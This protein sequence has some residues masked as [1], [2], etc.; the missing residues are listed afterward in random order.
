MELESK[1]EVLRNISENLE[2]SVSS[3]E[4]SS[5]KFS[6]PWYSCCRPRSF[7]SFDLRSKNEQ[8]FVVD[9][10]ILEGSLHAS[11][12]EVFRCKNCS[13]VIE[14]ERSGYDARLLFPGIN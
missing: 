4:E 2:D 12:S 9:V 13:E 6:P 3:S 10:E 14:F 11:P 5:I 1:D 7:A 8:L